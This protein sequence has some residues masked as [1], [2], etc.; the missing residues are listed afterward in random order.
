MDHES[1]CGGRLVPRVSAEGGLGWCAV[2]ASRDIA[3]AVSRALN[4]TLSPTVPGPRPGNREQWRALIPCPVI[5][6][7]VVRADARALWCRIGADTADTAD[8]AGSGVFVV[9]SA[10]WTT[11]ELVGCPLPDLVSGLPA[12]GRLSVHLVV[13]TTRMGR[14]IRYLAPT[15]RPT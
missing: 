4:G 1:G 5:P 7:T 2:T 3:A 12:S 14:L 10:P 8:A 9:R 6:V 13:L 15:F 11:G